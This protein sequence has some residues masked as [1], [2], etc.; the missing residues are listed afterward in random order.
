MN[1]SGNGLRNL[2]VWTIEDR[3]GD[4]SLTNDDGGELNTS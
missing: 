4:T 3:A 1:P 2:E